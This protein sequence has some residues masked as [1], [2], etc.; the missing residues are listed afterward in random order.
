M[1]DRRLCCPRV[2][3]AISYIRAVL[4]P[5]A[6]KIKLIICNDDVMVAA[7]LL[8]FPRC[9]SC[10]RLRACAGIGYKRAASCDHKPDRKKS[11]AEE[12]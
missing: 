6:L 12:K 5:Y 11:D 9:N 10:R 3:V 2:G 8:V 1:I 4:I 7:G